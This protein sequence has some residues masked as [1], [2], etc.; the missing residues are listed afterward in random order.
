MPARF[1]RSEGEGDGYGDG[2]RETGGKEGPKGEGNEGC[3]GCT[4]GRVEKERV[5]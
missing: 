2:D 3:E 4:E 1:G 5:W